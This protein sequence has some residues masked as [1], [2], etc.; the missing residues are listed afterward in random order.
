MRRQTRDTVFELLL[1]RQ[2]A[3]VTE[4]ILNFYE[5]MAAN[6]EEIPSE[7]IEEFLALNSKT[8]S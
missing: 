3:C 4:N 7:I 1:M 5:H 6:I 2:S 8:S